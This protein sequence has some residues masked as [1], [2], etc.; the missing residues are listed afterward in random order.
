MPA[1]VMRL[2]AFTF[3]RSLSRLGVAWR[4]DKF[5][6]AIFS[7]VVVFVGDIDRV[8]TTRI[9]NHWGVEQVEVRAGVTREEQL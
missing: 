5:A 7:V 9:E 4:L 3:L 8:L 6:L 2:R 1:Q